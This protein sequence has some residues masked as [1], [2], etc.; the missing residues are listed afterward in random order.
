MI[1]LEDRIKTDTHKARPDRRRRWLRGICLFCSTYSYPFA[2]CAE[3]KAKRRIA[4]EKQR[5]KYRAEGKCPSCGRPML[6][7]G[8]KLRCPICMEYCL[9]YR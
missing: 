2:L 5:L 4:T 3:H 7:E 9:K 6:L 1:P 8:T